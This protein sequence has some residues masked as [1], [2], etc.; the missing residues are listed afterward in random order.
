MY[1][2]ENHKDPDNMKNQGIKLTV[3]LAPGSWVEVDDSSV[4]SVH[5]IEKTA[6]SRAVMDFLSSLEPGDV[7]IDGYTTMDLGLVMG[8]VKSDSSMFQSH[9]ILRLQ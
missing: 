6:G 1:E 3:H 5:D 8:V 7:L 2:Y 9:N 4:P